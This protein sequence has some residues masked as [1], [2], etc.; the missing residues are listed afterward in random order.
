M[1]VWGSP[2]SV[3]E[4]LVFEHVRFELTGSPLNAVAGGNVDLRGAAID[5]PLFARDLP[6]LL[7][8]YVKGV[9]VN[10][11]QLQWSVTDAPFFTHGIELN[12]FEDVRIK[13]FKGTAYPGNSKAYPVY[14][15]DGK[16]LISDVKK[17]Q[18]VNVTP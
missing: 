18:A 4:D 6:A 14:A 8:Q 10:D 12:H 7:L 11:L 5:K 1:L 2:E 17:M 16:G 15:K 3:I 9:Q 13:D